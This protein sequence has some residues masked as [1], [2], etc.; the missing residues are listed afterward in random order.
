MEANT[1]WRALGH[2][3]WWL[4]YRVAPDKRQGVRELAR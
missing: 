1:I 4:Q 3:A 2:L